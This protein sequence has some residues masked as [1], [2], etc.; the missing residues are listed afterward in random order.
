MVQRRAVAEHNREA[1]AYA[2][3]LYATDRR[4]YLATD[5]VARVLADASGTT[6]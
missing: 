4:G 1:H 5:P 2:R 3:Y 6:I